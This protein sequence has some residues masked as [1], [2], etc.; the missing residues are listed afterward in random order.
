M[1]NDRNAPPAVTIV[2]ISIGQGAASYATTGD[3]IVIK[4]AISENIPNAVA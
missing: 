3:A 1:N 4:F 2:T